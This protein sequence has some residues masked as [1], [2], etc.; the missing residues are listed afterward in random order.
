ML[1][2]IYAQPFE[3]AEAWII[4]DAKSLKALRDA[5]DKALTDATISS[6]KSITADGESFVTIVANVDDWGEGIDVLPL[7]YYAA[8]TPG[9]PFEHFKKEVYKRLVREPEFGT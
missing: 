7:P 4:G 5:I 2:H 9:S 3:H 1:L 6:V 8:T